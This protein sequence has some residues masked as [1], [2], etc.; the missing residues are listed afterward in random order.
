MVHANRMTELR[1]AVELRADDSRQ[2]PGRI[3]GT[4]LT[5]GQ[6]ASDRPEGLCCKVR[7][8]GDVSA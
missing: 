8:V 3:V 6:R 1:C 7:L 5:Y 4:L 2:S